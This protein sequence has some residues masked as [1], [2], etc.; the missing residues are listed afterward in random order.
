MEEYDVE[1]ILDMYESDYVRE[2]R[3]MMSNG[4]LLEEY[5]GKSQL[6]YQ[7]AVKDGFQ[8]T[9][10]EYLRLMSPTKSF[11]EGGR[12]PFA[13]G[14]LVIKKP[15][16]LTGMAGDRKLTADQIAALDPDYKGQLP[17]KRKVKT[18]NLED[19]VE[20][21]NIIIKNK[22]HVGSLEELG[23][24]SDIV[25]STGKVDHRKTRLALDLA[26]DSFDEL[27]GFKLADVKYPKIDAKK[28]KFLDMVAKSF[29]NHNNA[30][31]ALEAAAHLLPDNMG[32]IV[33][34]GG[35]T[36]LEKGFFNLKGKITDVDKKFISERVASLTDKEFSI[37]NV[38]E[39]I[40][41]TTKVRRSEGSIAAKL[42]RNARMN[43]QIKNLADDE[44]IQNLLKGDLNRKTQ[45]ALLERATQLVGGDASIASRRL[46][47]M[48]E[49]MSDTTD[50]YK[51]LGIKLNNNKANKII[52]TGKQIG[53]VNNRYGMSSVL[54]D[55]YGNVVD[56]ALGA[57]EG[58]TFIGK[59][60]QQIKNLLDKGQS[61]DEIFSLTASARRGMS[62][63]AIFTQNL[64]TDVNS[65]IKGA[66]IDSALSK[67]HE[68]L[69]EIFQGKTYNQLNA[70]EK[71]AVNEL[72][73]KFEEI[74]VN[75]LNQP[76]NPGAVEKGAKPIYLTAEEKKNIQLPE[77][78]LKNPPS[79]A[80]AGYK[81]FDKNLQSAFDTSYKNVGYSMKVPKG[82]LTQKQMIADLTQG[83]SKFG[84]KGKI[85]A[86]VLAGVL[87]Y[88]SEDILKGTGLMDKEYELTASAA[89][90]PIVEKGLSTG[91]KTAIGTGTA[92]GLGTKIGR[93]LLGKALNLGFGP[94]GILGINAY[95][96]IDPKESL[97]RAMLGVEGALL[98]SAVK[99]TLSVTDKIKNPALRKIVERATLAGLSPA[100]AMRL[101]RVTNPVGI[102][103]LAGEGLYQLGKRGYNQYQQMKDM[104]EQEKSE[105]LADQYEDLGG[106][107]GEGA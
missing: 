103:T 72:V 44:I 83:V 85:A 28:F 10:E 21:R 38:N 86:S 37:D 7:Q 58:K 51:N 45:E 101:A 90:A 2:P 73:E 30:T 70:K 67:K 80:I 25:G 34:L 32:K 98:P 76:I 78:D 99:G 84:S 104:T 4:G 12:I 13:P 11:A 61:P 95:L 87:G 40:E 68:Q 57:T 17:D 49:A 55:Y 66:Y 107:F 14:K 48:A 46:F 35:R 42:K 75:A 64:R 88:K 81:D 105:F 18:S 47:Q 36:D 82:Y 79:K 16:T 6:E 62:P 3:P 106:V 56:K 53:G 19:A 94:T 41:K 93:N 33:D 54:Y 26:L 89:D 91:E 22:G 39:L 102:A 59:Y 43:E 15:K 63:Y 8:G 24:L 65:A 5:Y 77:F 74:K 9:Y 100:M 92:L 50:Q 96:G 52:A 69:Q 71:A 31:D 1:S 29:V 20:V 60:Q 27:K 97:D 23:R